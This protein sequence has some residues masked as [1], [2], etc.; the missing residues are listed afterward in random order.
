MAPKKS[1]PSG[2]QEQSIKSRQHQLYDQEPPPVDATGRV[3]VKSVQDYLRETPAAPLSPALKAGLWAAGGVI[4]LL[5][6]AVVMMGGRRSRGPSGENEDSRITETSK[7]EGKSFPQSPR[8]ELASVV[9]GPGSAR[10]GRA[11]S[12][13]RKSN[14]QKSTAAQSSK[15]R[16]ADPGAPAVDVVTSWKVAVD[17]PAQPLEIPASQDLTLPVPASAQGGQKV[18]YPTTP[19]PFV[20]VG[21]NG[22]DAETREVW[23][24][25][26]KKRAGLIRG[27]L[28]ALPPFAVSPDGTYLA[29]RVT[30]KLDKNDQNKNGN[31][32]NSSDAY[33]NKKDQSKT[34]KS[35]KGKTI[36]TIVN[37]WSFKNGK[38]S[39][40]IKLERETID[41]ID[42]AGPEQLLTGDTADRSF[43]VWS[44]ESGEQVGEFR[45]PWPV[46]R[47]S[48]ALSPGRQ[49]LAMTSVRD[50]LM[51]I[52]DLTTR[53]AAGEVSLPKIGPPDWACAGM[54]FSNDGKELAAVF[55]AAGGPRI[56][57]WN[58]ATGKTDVDHTLNSH[59]QIR[60]LP[61]DQGRAL[62]WLPSGNA[63]LIYGHALID[64]PSGRR[65]WSLPLIVPEF[66]PAPRR[67]VD[68]DRALIVSDQGRTQVLRAAVMPKD[69]LMAARQLVRMAGGG[70][71]VDAVL[72]PLRPADWSFQHT[73]PD[74]SK[75]WSVAPD[76]AIAPSKPLSSRPISLR[77]K[78]FEVDRILCTGG[79]EG[80]ALVSIKSVDRN[81]ATGNA[82]AAGFERFLD[83]Y[84]LTTGKRLAY[85]QVPSVCDVV[86]FSPD[87]GRILLRDSE[88]QDRLD[89]YSAADLRFLAGWRPYEKE[90][91]DARTVVWTAFL[92]QYRALTINST[93]KLVLWALPDCRVIYTVRDSLQGV[94]VLSPGR[95]TLAGMA[96]GVIRFFDAATGK[97]EGEA[98]APS[99]DDGGRPGLRAAAFRFDGQQLA[100]IMRNGVLVR[101][102][103]ASGKPL[104][105]FRL[106]FSGGNMI[107]WCGPNHV[108]VDNQSLIDLD[109]QWE[110]WLYEGG[111]PFRGSP[112]GRHW[113]AVENY[114]S[115]P[116]YLAAFTLP[117]KGLERIVRMVT[118]PKSPALLRA[119]TPVSLILETST[120][121]SDADGFRRTILEHFAG[122]LRACDIKVLDGQTVSLVVK[123]DEVDTGEKV[124]L[125]YLYPALAEGSNAKKSISIKQLEFEVFFVDPTGKVTYEPRQ[126]VTLRDLSDITIP[127]GEKDPSEFIRNQLWN[128]AKNR[129]MKVALPPYLFRQAEGL[130]QFPGISKYSQLLK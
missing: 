93:G 17:A 60:R 121:P 114:A 44:I 40:Q 82:L 11:K 119:G 81:D 63:W 64:R 37:I 48:L 43:Q 122:Q 80:Q 123:V 14:D 120:K 76:P 96:G 102:D 79:E 53:T 42:F 27:A 101:F 58:I 21:D 47:Q 35:D 56:V 88:Y 1:V 10:Q 33:R 113:A 74:A 30:P 92:D 50:G 84:D 87:A 67:F 5:F 103:V 15:E 2:K 61:D 71:A 41:F 109:R 16:E 24:L 111:I 108:I 12:E 129:L 112:D 38:E 116:A 22:S 32:D 124:E 19:S 118:D 99:S 45:T 115:E 29:A 49:Y 62:E 127:A 20:V 52:Y 69:T 105:E 110:V 9:R 68:N 59:F 90:T 128:I 91:G 54:T 86:A 97:Q 39:K 36:R 78:L 100:I 107:E 13:S 28:R 130:V 104:S 117:E 65:I 57:C 3:K 70:S 126:A 25:R 31:R 7:S 66:P 55:E 4:V 98:P 6:A 46:D 26:T 51:R 83:R 72:P 125:R 89:L 18:L 95:K 75:T 8:R 23:D 94:P 77:N 34:K 73:V 85:N 106:P